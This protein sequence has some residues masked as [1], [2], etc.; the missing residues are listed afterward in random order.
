MCPGSG[1]AGIMVKATNAT[2]QSGRPAA[3][4]RSPVQRILP[5]RVLAELKDHAAKVGEVTKEWVAEFD[6][7]HGIEARYGVTPRRLKNFLQRTMGAEGHCESE[8]SPAVA[9]DEKQWPARLREHRRRQASIAS[10]LDVTFGMMADCSPD[11]WGRRA[12]LMLVGLVYERL[13]AGHDEVPTE[14]IVALAKVLAENRRVEVRLQE[15][16][17]RKQTESKPEPGSGRLPARFGEIVREVYGTN[18]Q[19]TGDAQEDESKAGGV[20]G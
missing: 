18:F 16:E 20:G 13:A 14:E 9:S 2:K 7:E 6:L 8:S 1:A 17:G 5:P 4:R 10:I 11:L 15:M 12:Y 19:D 3:A